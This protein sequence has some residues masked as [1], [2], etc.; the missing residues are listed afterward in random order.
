MP[1]K[2]KKPTLRGDTLVE[3]MFAIG[4]FAM[5][6]IS[7]T[8][9]MNSMLGKSQSAI[10][11]VMSR[12]EID[13]QAE[14]IR[15]IQSSNK[16]DVMREVWKKIADNAI[17]AGTSSSFDPSSFLLE[18]VGSCEEFNDITAHP[19]LSHAFYI[20]TFSLNPIGDPL[21][22][23]YV[24]SNADRIYRNNIVTADVF[25]RIYHAINDPTL[26]GSGFI[27]GAA[28]SQA[29][30]IWVVAVK[31]HE[32]TGLGVLGTD[33][34]YYDFYIQTCW[35]PV[36]KATMPNTTNTIIRLRNP[37]KT[38]GSA[39]TTCDPTAKTTIEFYDGDP[40]TTLVYD[41]TECPGTPVPTPSP[42]P[43][44]GKV[45]VR[46]EDAAGQPNPSGV[47]STPA[48]GTAK[49]HAKYSSCKSHVILHKPD[50][51]I[52]SNEE[53]AC[54]SALTDL[55]S[56]YSLAGYT[57]AWEPLGGGTA[58]SSITYPGSDGATIEYK[59]VPTAITYH[60]TTSGVHIWGDWSTGTR[61]FSGDL[62]CADSSD[63]IN[64]IRTVYS[65]SINFYINGE[66]ITLDGSGI[67]YD[68]KIEFSN[69]GAEEA[70]QFNASRT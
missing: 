3:V 19:G 11:I 57:I 47:Y 4:I 70:P 36:G 17:D 16:N 7:V 54:N 39:A 58:V 23:N 59:A 44:A 28:D 21:A 25:P 63:I 64:S 66:T 65:G 42:S 10:E 69:C 51:T 40:P 30:G 35:N 13:A 26:Y 37:N 41:R 1:I 68:A 31:G 46:W 22:A 52:I 67:S 18:N 60:Y 32:S 29:Q 34:D 53:G 38:I 5:V 56:K 20:D 24:S 61:T 12:S 8:T 43:P 62:S 45:F 50:G 15:F 55:A 2:D 48:S 14:A 49:W 9:L 6:A 33:V 27:E